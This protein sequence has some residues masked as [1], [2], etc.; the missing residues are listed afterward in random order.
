MRI[1]D[2]LPRRSYQDLR[3]VFSGS[4]EKGGEDV[5][6]Q[7]Y[8]G[9]EPSDL[10]TVVGRKSSDTVGGGVNAIG[11]CSNAHAHQQNHDC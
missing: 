5:E 7:V 3:A 9:V 6:N 4:E 2:F 8:D 10:G 11:P 1:V